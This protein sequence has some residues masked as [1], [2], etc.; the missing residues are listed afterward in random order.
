MEDGHK[1]GSQHAACQLCKLLQHQDKNC[2]TQYVGNMS[3]TLLI[4]CKELLAGDVMITCA[5]DAATYNT[6]QLRCSHIQHGSAAL[7]A[8][9][10]GLF[11]RR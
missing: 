3:R 8:A 9:T 10:N 7:L 4:G 2:S 6:A 11:C 1:L 5:T